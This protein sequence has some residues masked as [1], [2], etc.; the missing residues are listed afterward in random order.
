MATGNLHDTSGLAGSVPESVSVEENVSCDP[1]KTSE[2]QSTTGAEISD[3]KSDNVL[4]NSCDSGAVI[5]SSDIQNN[6]K[7]ADFSL[8]V[9]SC[10]SLLDLQRLRQQLLLT[11]F[12]SLVSLCQVFFYGNYHICL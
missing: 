2:K 11:A 6:S 9:A 3:E 10:I 8:G 12:R 4:P 7:E 1:G 5:K